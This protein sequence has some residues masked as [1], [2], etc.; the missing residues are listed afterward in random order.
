MRLILD[1]NLLRRLCHTTHHPDLLEWLQAWLERELEHD[2]TGIF[3][4]A[5]VEFEL[6]RGYLWQLDKH[7]SV[8]FVLA[9]LDMYCDTLTVLPITQQTLHRAA[10]LWADAR[11]GGYKTAPDHHIDWDVIIASQAL[12]LGAVVVTS[13]TRHFTCYGADARDWPDI[14]APSG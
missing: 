8:R 9:R 4:S 14:A 10:Q 1:T 7:P 11:R 6:R 5:A 2:D 13:N 3:I 12:E